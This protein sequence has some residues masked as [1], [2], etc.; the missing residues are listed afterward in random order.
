[1]K[2][3]AI[4]AGDLELL[5][6]TN[7]AEVESKQNFSTSNPSELHKSAHKSTTLSD[8]PNPGHTHVKCIIGIDYFPSGG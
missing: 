3:N 4:S 8:S 7:Q 6:F 1:M 2:I 5:D